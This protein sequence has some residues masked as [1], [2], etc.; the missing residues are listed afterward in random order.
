MLSADCQLRTGKQKHGILR[1]VLLPTRAHTYWRRQIQDISVAR[2]IDDVD[3]ASIATGQVDTGTVAACG[4]RHAEA[5]GGAESVEG[6][7][8]RD[9]C[10]A[11]DSVARDVDDRHLLAE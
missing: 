5:G 3:H 1:Q 4:H 10:R 8:P 7:K 9:C 11:L 2:G 6:R